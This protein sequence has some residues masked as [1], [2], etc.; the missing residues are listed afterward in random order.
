M[1]IKQYEI[2][3]SRFALAL[4]DWRT[5]LLCLCAHR[6][7]SH[8]RTVGMRHAM[9]IGALRAELKAKENRS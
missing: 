8:T 4:T 2:E 3:I 5:K 7:I 1:P 9:E 6:G